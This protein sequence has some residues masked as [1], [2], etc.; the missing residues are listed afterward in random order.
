MKLRQY[1]YA[2]GIS[3]AKEVNTTAP[4]IF[5]IAASHNSV[6]NMSAYQNAQ[7]LASQAQEIVA[8]TKTLLPLNMAAATTSTIFKVANDLSQLK[9]TI[10]TKSPY[11]VK[12]RERSIR[13]SM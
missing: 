12:S 13:I 2:L 11:E 7:T 4:A 1:G 10:E 6:V 8:Q 5:A 3:S 9:N